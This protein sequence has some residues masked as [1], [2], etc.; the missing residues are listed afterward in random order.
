MKEIH[1][2]SK[3]NADGHAANA[4]LITDSGGVVVTSGR[5]NVNELN[6]LHNARSNL[7]T[8]IDEC[9]AGNYS[10]PDY[11]SFQNIDASSIYSG[12]TAPSNGLIW[13]YIKLSDY[14]SYAIH[15]DTEQVYGQSAR[16]YGGHYDNQR[17]LIKK[18]SILKCTAPSSSGVI[19][20]ARFYPLVT[21]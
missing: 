2:V 3:L 4:V 6:M 7:Q 20:I 12:Y 15:I 1:R 14:Y 10:V 19:I 5:V 8:Q 9:T 11:S 18:G 17:F 21:A 13:L 16:S